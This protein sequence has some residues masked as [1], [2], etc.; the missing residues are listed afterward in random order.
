ML[1]IGWNKKSKNDFMK[2]LKVLENDLELLVRAEVEDSL[3]KIE[4]EAA[5]KVPVDFGVLKNS[6]QSNPIKVQGGVI[7]GGVSVGAKYAPFVEFGTGTKVDVPAELNSYAKQYKG[8]GVKKLNL[9]ARPFFYPEVWKQRNDLPKK[10]EQ[11]LIKLM[12]RK[13]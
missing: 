11:G 12:K 4:S 6:I 3:L 7:S 10:I 2:Y 13:Q 9:P 1:T 8:D 5:S